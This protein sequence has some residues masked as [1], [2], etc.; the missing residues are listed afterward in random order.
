M[1]KLY[2]GLEGSSKER[3]DRE[4]FGKIGEATTTK[5][6]SFECYE[7]MNVEGYLDSLYRG[8]PITPKDMMNMSE[9]MQDLSVSIST[10]AT[11][12]RTVASEQMLLESLHFKHMK[13]RYAGIAQ[14]H[15]KT[16]SWVFETGSG[17]S[18]LTKFIC[19]HYRTKE[20][21]NKW[22]G[23]KKLV[24]A[25]YFFWNAGTK[26]QKSQ[27][28]L[29]QSLLFEILR[30]CPEL[31]PTACCKWLESRPYQNEP[32][33]WTRENLLH[34]FSQLMEQTD[35][36]A[37]FCFIDGLDEYDGNH[38]EL[39]KVLQS[40][41]VSSDIKICLSSRPWYSFKDAFGQDLERLLKIED[42]T[43]ED[44]RLYVYSKFEESPRFREIKDIDLRY[45]ELVTEIVDKAQG[46]FLWVFLVVRSLLQ[47]LTYADRISDLQRRL[48]LLPPTLE[49][50]FHHMLNS[51]E[52]VYREQIAQTFEVVLCATEPLSLITFSFLDEDDPDFAF[53]TKFQPM[54]DTEIHSRH[55]IMR[56]RLDGR[57]KGLLEVIQ[58]N[59]NNWGIFFNYKVDFLHRSVRDFLLTRHMQ[60]LLEDHLDFPFD[61]RIAI[62]SA[63]VAQLKSLPHFKEK[64]NGDDGP[65]YELL[66]QVMSYAKKLEM[67]TNKSLFALLDEAGKAV[68]HPLSC[69]KWKRKNTAFLGFAIQHNLELGS[70]IWARFLAYLRTTC[71]WN[72]DRN[73]QKTVR[74]L[75]ANGADLNFPLPDG[76]WVGSRIRTR[77]GSRTTPVESLFV[78]ASYWIVSSKLSPEFPLE[79]VKGWMEMTQAKAF[80]VWQLVYKGLA[81]GARCPIPMESTSPLVICIHIGSLDVND[82]TL[83]PLYDIRPQKS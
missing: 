70:A 30:K 52:E 46:V 67:E 68:Y 55:E 39:V 4:S 2:G 5:Q 35:I 9:K 7:T 45:S 50:Y 3:L 73:F 78:T 10:L 28:G 43:R 37:R 16:Y 81:E 71:A 82:K 83:V 19:D 21:L 14:A 18:T 26:L 11:V 27:E 8:K 57:C 59:Y 66:V 76:F 58:D 31:I 74:L 17:K 65:V 79:V 56:R 49:D 69:W 75:V 44:I 13:A 72:G 36:S 62:A 40:L 1:G 42:L 22:A 20:E 63:L 33:F 32:D 54:N 53:H 51:V 64:D 77:T 23:E 47:G 80:S 29:L 25:K 12:G 60:Q 6:A 34:T 15:A 48:G 61:P 24:T 38:D 41:A